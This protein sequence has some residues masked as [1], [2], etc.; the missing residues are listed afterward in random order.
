MAVYIDDSRNKYRGMIMS[1]M[2]ADSNSE[3]MR[4]ADDLGLQHK[5]IQYEGTKKEHF[6]V[7]QQ[8]KKIAIHKGAIEISKREL[9][10]MIQKREYQLYDY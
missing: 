6:D 8:Y 2:I 9:V 10:Y 4:M 7:C 1:H 5:H 3:L